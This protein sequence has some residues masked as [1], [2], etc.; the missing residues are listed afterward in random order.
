MRVYTY[1][2]V[3]DTYYMY[4]VYMYTCSSASRNIMK[5]YVYFVIFWISLFV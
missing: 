1:N 5:T 4:I 3:H 2:V